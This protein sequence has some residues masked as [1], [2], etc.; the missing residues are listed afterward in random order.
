VKE[1]CKLQEHR[2]RERP[3]HGRHYSVFATCT[4]KKIIVGMVRVA[5]STVD[6]FA[7]CVSQG[8][9]F[10]GTR[11]AW[12]NAHKDVGRLDAGL[13]TSC[14]KS[15]VRCGKHQHLLRAGTQAASLDLQDKK[16]WKVFRKRA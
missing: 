15:L 7:W 2:S 3:L 5:Q 11:D 14:D 13:A 1:S 6:L 16:S 12:R 9:R 10:V 8:H 4:Q